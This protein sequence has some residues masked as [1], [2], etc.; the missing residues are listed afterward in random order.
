MFVPPQ[1]MR[2]APMTP[3]IAPEAPTNGV[4]DVGFATT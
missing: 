2:N 4:T 1:R 3:A